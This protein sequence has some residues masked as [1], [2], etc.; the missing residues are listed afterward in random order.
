MSEETHWALSRE[1]LVDLAALGAHWRAAFDAA[2][3]ALHAASLYLPPEEVRDDANRLAA[4][5]E[6]TA[7]LLRALAADRRASGQFS[8][9]MVSSRDTRDLLGLPSGVRACV[10]NLDGVLIGS[11]AI[12]TAAWAET[13]DEFISRRIERTGGRF[14]PFNARID[15]PLHIHGKPRLDGVRAFLASRGISLP[16][17]DA[18]DP[19]ELETV[20]GLANR[21]NQA[22]QRQLDKH[23][24]HAFDGSRRYL[25]LAHDADLQCA[26]VSASANTET[27][28]QRSGLAD[29]IDERVDGNTVTAERLRAKPAPDTL[30][31]ACRKLGVDPQHAVSF[32]T[33]PAGI[34][35]ARA[36]AFRIVIAV[37]SAGNADAL[38]AEAPDVVVAGLA[39][40]LN[41]KL[42]A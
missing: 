20:H 2:D 5:R 10:F 17:G 25:E 24:V 41:Q 40:L 4:E 23:G 16:E 27:I 13:F 6:P 19:P 26:V 36:A 28:L 12:H 11:A 18:A 38:R 22:L 3:T 42:A 9:L 31:A 8:A 30:L 29:L 15:Y 34:T 35:A 21:K 39:E 37:N 32:E 14:A 1:P 7:A 33:T